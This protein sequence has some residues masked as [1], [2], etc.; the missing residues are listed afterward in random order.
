MTNIQKTI[1]VMDSNNVSEF[2]EHGEEISVAQ[3]LPFGA[4]CSNKGC[5]DSTISTTN[6]P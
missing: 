4:P 5:N 3:M 2:E 1:G 6:A